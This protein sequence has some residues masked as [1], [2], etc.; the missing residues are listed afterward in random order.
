MRRGRALV[1]AGRLATA[2]AVQ[3]EADLVVAADG[4][5]DIALGLGWR[6][7]AVVGDQDSASRSALDR[8]RRSGVEIRSY[9]ARKN[10]TDLELA[11]EFACQRVDEVRVL[12]SAAG[13]LDHALSGLL[14]LASPRW[15]GAK[16][17][18]TVD[19]AHVEVVRGQ[20]SIAGA[21]GDTISLIAVGGPAH[22]ART[23]GLEYPLAN[24]VLQPTEARGVSNVIVAHP[25][26]IE[27]VE[28]VLLAVSPSGIEPHQ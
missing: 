23:W 25:A 26:G 19:S 1:I 24:E 4:G 28:G 15:A 9:P 17:S 22:V 27:V 14:V 5:L 8:A 6:V 10:E 7:D 11:L 3:P 18:A 21:V 16:V 12:A 2:P 20:R 13:R